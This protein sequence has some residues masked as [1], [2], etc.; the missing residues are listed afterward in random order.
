MYR[1][2]FVP[3]DGSPFAEQAIAVALTLAEP[4]DAQVTLVRAWEPAAY[5][6]SSELTPPFLAGGSADRPAAAEYLDLLAARVRSGTSATI[7]VALVSGT[8]PEAIAE[9]LTH[10][11]DDLVVMTTHGLTGWNRAWLGSVADAVVRTVAAPVLLVRPLE[12]ATAA[13]PGH[14]ECVLVPLD[15]SSEAEEILTHATEVGGNARY[16]LL[17]VERPVITPLHPYAYAAPASQT[18][19]EATEALVTR[20]R[21]YLTGIAQSVRAR[22]PKAI[23]DVDVRLAERTG[24]AIV[25]AAQD[26]RADLVA[27]TTHARRAARLVLGSVADKV[28]RGTHGSVLVLRPTSVA[29]RRE[30][31]AAG[32]AADSD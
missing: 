27:L 9:C 19:H 3:V 23:V 26:Y 10:G 6:Y 8:P 29:A 25:E 30:P 31:A 22:R 2:I 11:A 20:A 13:T 1:S 32:V 17:R 24:A 21:D 5:R 18:D 15:G 7:R 14:F 4:N 16:V 12:A 28:L